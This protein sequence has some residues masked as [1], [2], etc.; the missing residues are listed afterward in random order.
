MEFWIMTLMDDG[1]IIFRVNDVKYAYKIDAAHFPK[2]IQLSKNAE[3]ALSFIKKHG[4]LIRKEK[5]Y[6]SGR[7]AKRDRRID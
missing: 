3:R 2:I 5:N 1:E 7:L 6:G 4:K